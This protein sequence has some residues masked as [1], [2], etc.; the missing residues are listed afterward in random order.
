MKISLVTCNKLLLGTNDDQLLA[1]E[2]CRRGHHVEF[3]VWSDNS[4]NWKHFDVIVLRSTWDYCEHLSDFLKWAKSVESH[5]LLL[6][7]S[8]TLSWNHEKKYLLELAEKNISVVPTKIFS[9]SESK[10]PFDLLKL[11]PQIV[12]KP[13][14]SASA[15][16]TFKVQS[17]EQVRSAVK[18]IT[19][20]SRVIA[21][22]FISSVAKEG[23]VSLVFVYDKSWSYSHAV[24]KIPKANDFRVQSE[25][26]GSVQDFIPSVELINF[27]Y[28][29]LSCVPGRCLLARVDIVN[30]WQ[31]PLIMEI[32]LIEPELFFRCSKKGTQKVVQAIENS[33]S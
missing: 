30:W 19:A 23:E 14:V 13:E 27:S 20:H 17:E 3:K 7:S 26:G 18:S 2:L 22:P 28:Q 4:I 24:Q 6:N 29:A 8:Q 25:H 9:S 32:E 31:Q 11:Y 5:S 21:Q 10:D 1:A 15:K 12:L 16:N 33:L